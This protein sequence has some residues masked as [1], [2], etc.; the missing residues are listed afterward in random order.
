MYGFLN[1][2]TMTNVPEV[3]KPLFEKKKD[4][5]YAN[6]FIQGR[7]GIAVEP[8][9]NFMLEELSQGRILIV[10]DKEV[11]NPLKKYPMD[12][13]PE[14]VELTARIDTDFITSIEFLKFPKII[15]GSKKIIT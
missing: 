5:D 13:G 14:T 6:I 7:P 3:L 1:H 11:P 8:T 15:T 12:P 10:T 9:T 4:W 2:I